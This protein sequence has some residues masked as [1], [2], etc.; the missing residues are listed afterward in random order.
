MSTFR[1]YQYDDHT[2]IPF[3]IVTLKPSETEDRETLAHRHNYYELFV[4]SEPGVHH[5]IDFEEHAVAA[6]QVHLVP[7]GRVHLLRRSAKTQ[8][9]VLLF[10]REF[11]LLKVEQQANSLEE[12][13]LN[14]RLTSYVFDFDEQEFDLLLD[15]IKIIQ[16]VEINDKH[17]KKEM[18]SLQ[19]NSLLQLVKSK[20]QLANF[21]QSNNLVFD[22]IE[23][24][25]SNLRT[26]HSVHYYCSKLSISSAQLN[27]AC[28]NFSG[29][30]ASNLIKERLV[31]ESKR[32]LFQSN[33]SVKEIAY[34][35]GFQDP[36]YFSRW[37]ALNGG[38]PAKDIRTYLRANFS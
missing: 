34:Y 15:I 24:L 17:Y 20:L 36:S 30:S 11:Y 32:L 31:I 10:S 26:E 18:V 2:S 25:E 13:I 6:R 37:I 35:L 28:K 5:F 7:P 21:N 29:K 1:N 27:E 12:I 4:F 3:K 22:F 16:R 19:L 33:D 8:G 38:M 9:F 14:H 23:L